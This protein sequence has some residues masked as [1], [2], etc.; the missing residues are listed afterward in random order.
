MGAGNESERERKCEEF[1]EVSAA[2]RV[3]G[4]HERRKRLNAGQQ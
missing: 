4:V 1:E 2:R 3:N